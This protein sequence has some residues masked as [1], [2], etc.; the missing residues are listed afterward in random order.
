MKRINI[1]IAVCLMY[2]LLIGS[3]VYADFELTGVSIRAEG[4]GGTGCA[5]DYQSDMAVYNPALISGVQSY[6]IGVNYSMLYLGLS[7]NSMSQFFVNFAG[8]KIPEI[9]VMTGAQFN[10]FGVPSL[11]SEMIYS[12][13]LAKI[14]TFLP[15]D[16]LNPPSIGLNINFLQKSFGENDYTKVDNF[17]SQNGYSANGY[18]INMG[19][20]VPLGDLS[21]LNDVKIGLSA[22]NI[23]RP[24]VAIGAGGE[25]V[26]FVLRAGFSS[27]IKT[28]LTS[29]QFQTGEVNILGV[30]FEKSLK[31][32][33]LRLGGKF[34]DVTEITAGFGF[35]Y[36]S[37]LQADYSFTYAVAGISSSAGTHRLGII[38][39][40]GK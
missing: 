32:F 3:S 26:P 8:F 39:K 2:G 25:S 17:F 34:I 18:S 30:G 37:S 28:F 7:D 36:K 4:L 15:L 40:F 13:T 31:Q 35:N 6:Q 5:L 27:L 20:L 33:A 22:D 10:Y 19:I 1:F 38:F 9:D 11:Y 21:I 23:N 16:K 24:V 12:L 14:L 29:L